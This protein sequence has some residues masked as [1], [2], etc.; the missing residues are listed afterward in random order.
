MTRLRH[1]V[2]TRGS[3]KKVQLAFNITIPISFI[4]ISLIVPVKF[5]LRQQ[6]ETRLSLIPI[7]QN[8]FLATDQS[9]S[10]DEK[11]T[12]TTKIIKLRVW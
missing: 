10:I 5:E 12:Q 6:L 4:N 7:V 3:N 9:L 2:I 8:Q 11:V 1:E